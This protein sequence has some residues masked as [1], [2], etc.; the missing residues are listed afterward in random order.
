MPEQ[1]SGRMTGHPEVVPK[2][3]LAA[4]APAPRFQLP[5]ESADKTAAGAHLDVERIHRARRLVFDSDI[6]RLRLVADQ[7]GLERSRSQEREIHLAGAAHRTVIDPLK[8][9]IALAPRQCREV[10]N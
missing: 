3:P 4:A 10:A 9:H 5:G 8:P 6:V 7:S 2:R 1:G